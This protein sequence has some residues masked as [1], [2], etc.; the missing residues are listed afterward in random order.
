MKSETWRQFYCTVKKDKCFKHIL[1]KQ[2]IPSVWEDNDILTILVTKSWTGPITFGS[3]ASTKLAKQMANQI[4][5]NVGQLFL[6]RVLSTENT[7]Q[8]PKPHVLVTFFFQEAKPMY[9]R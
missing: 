1:P 8:L 7:A 2:N 4:Q 3:K 9:F 6:E 5:P